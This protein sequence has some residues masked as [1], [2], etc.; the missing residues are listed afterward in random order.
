MG[1]EQHLANL[2]DEFTTS[3]DGGG[4]KIIPKKRNGSPDIPRK[5]ECTGQSLSVE[6]FVN[7]LELELGRDLKAKT[8]GLEEPD[9]LNTLSSRHWKN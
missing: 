7:R 4:R 2:D 6:I 9:K 3:C 8:S 5:H 1:M